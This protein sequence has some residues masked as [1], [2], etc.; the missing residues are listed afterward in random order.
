[1]KTV[2]IVLVVLGGVMVFSGIRLGLTTYDL[3]STHDLS[4][5]CGGLGFSVLI[6]LGG[7]ALIIKSK[8]KN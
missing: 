7:I 5:F 3:R 8:Q 6:L 2:G 1:M 4:K